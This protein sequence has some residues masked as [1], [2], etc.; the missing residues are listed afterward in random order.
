MMLLMEPT[1]TQ[2]HRGLICS[3]PIYNKFHASRSLCKKPHRY[4]DI[5]LA[6]ANEGTDSNSDGEID[7]DGMGAPATSKMY[8][9]L[10]A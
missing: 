4:A 10:E 8:S 6:A 2:T 3:R 9:Q 7:L 1:Y 5:V